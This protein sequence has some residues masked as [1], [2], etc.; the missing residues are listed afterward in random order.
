MSHS[1]TPPSPAA[2]APLAQGRTAEIY[3]WDDGHVLK[4]F[5]DWCPPD[6]VEYEAGIARAVYAAGVPSPAPGEIL[7]VNGRRGLIYE[8]LDGVSM[9][10]DL[11]THPWI[12]F[13]HARSLAELQVQI[14][15]QSI[16]GLP[17]YK[18]RLRHDIRKTKH[19]TEEMR[20]Q[21]LA[22]LAILP[23]QPNLC[24]GDYHPGNILITK[25]GP[26]V[27]DWMT[28]CSGSPWADAARTSM[29]LS[30][31][32]KGAQKQIHPIVRTMVKLY[33]RTYLNRY[34]VLSPDTEQEM[35]RWMPV[36]VAA[37]LNEDIPPE[38]A[39]LL[40]IIKEEM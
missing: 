16:P 33:H 5:R 12:A 11:N 22:R 23:D 2:P 10:Q 30:I 40:K 28:A 27:I 8:R 39:A 32:A 15:R 25:Q 9:L 14:N 1:L 6:W 38:R 37:R 7:E 36:I 26:V 20:E 3:P 17:S 24:H 4:L 31:G 19:L 21:V 13:K 34:H 18:D 35:D 29:T